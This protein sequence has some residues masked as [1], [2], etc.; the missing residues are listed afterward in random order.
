MYDDSIY[1]VYISNV[2]GTEGT[3]YAYRSLCMRYR[4]HFLN[5]II[6]MVHV[7]THTYMNVMTCVN[8]K[9]TT[10]LL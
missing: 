4:L 7:C 10:I 5:I 2:C 8:K 9:N 1:T 3:F 6:T